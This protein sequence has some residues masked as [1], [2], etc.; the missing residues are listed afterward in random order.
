M[1]VC[2]FGGSSLA[3]AACFKNAADIML[4]SHKRRVLVLS[5]PGKHLG[6]GEKITD[7]LFGIVE[8]N[9]RGRD[10][11]KA[12][13]LLS[14]RLCEI[15][16]ELLGST[17]ISEKLVESLEERLGLGKAYV[18]SLG[19]EFSCDIMVEYLKKKRKVS[20]GIF[21]PVHLLV[22]VNGRG[23]AYVPASSYQKI[24][25][26]LNPLVEK[27]K[28]V[29]VP[30]FFGTDGEGKRHLFSRGGSDYTAV[31]LGVVL[32]AECCEKF[33]D[34]DGVMDMNPR[35]SADAQVI[36]TLTY[37][38][39]LQIVRS[40]RSPV[41]HLDALKVAMEANLCLRIANSFNPNRSGTIVN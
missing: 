32:S 20:V 18:V 7:V 4:A 6:K 40:T 35:V 5:A 34:V 38:D 19:E 39:F 16:S 17:S 24:A 12:K 29:C 21:D 41:F 10:F 8:K 3:D 25:G 37:D 30:G 2:K 14:N 1:I 36:P 23:I 31:V 26:I 27:Y 9:N 13:E 33:T 15:E 11:S 28:I 22:E